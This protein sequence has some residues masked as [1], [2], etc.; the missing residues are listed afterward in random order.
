MAYE[1]ASQDEEWRNIHVR[2]TESC[3]DLEEDTLNWVSSTVMSWTHDNKG[4]FYSKYDEKDVVKGLEY[5]QIYYHRLGTTE[6]QDVKMYENRREQGEIYHTQ[7]SNDGRYLLIGI[8][9]ES[10]DNQT[11]KLVDLHDE[12]NK[13]LNTSLETEPLIKDWVGS[14]EYIHN[15]G[16]KFYFLTNAEAPRGQIVEIDASEP[17]IERIQDVWKVIMPQSDKYVLQQVVPMKGKFGAFFFHNAREK[18]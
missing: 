4:F 16:K 7:M 11:Y 5:H 14:F 8:D 17:T 2:C 1:I 13:Y 6:D 10:C 9:R 18:L 3:K 12:A 15:E